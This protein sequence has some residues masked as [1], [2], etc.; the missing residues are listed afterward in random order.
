[1]L[2]QNL[3]AEGILGEN[4]YDGWAKVRKRVSRPASSVGIDSVGIDSV[5]IDSVGIDS[6]EIDKA[7]AGR[8]L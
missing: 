3:Q 1:L 8:A 7:Q 5:G 2:R 6:V 4:M